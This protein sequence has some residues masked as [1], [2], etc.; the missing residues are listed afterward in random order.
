MQRSHQRPASSSQPPVAG[1]PAGRC[2]LTRRPLSAEAQPGRMPA[3]AHTSHPNHVSSH[4]L[5]D[6]SCASSSLQAASITACSIFKHAPSSTACRPLGSPPLGRSAPPHA[7]R[8]AAACFYLTPIVLL[9]PSTSA[10]L[11]P[12]TI[13]PPRRLKDCNCLLLFRACQ[14]LLSTAC[15]VFST[16][17][18]K[19]RRSASSL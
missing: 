11:P 5:P 3:Q 14:C 2:V 7:S 8:S 9:P 4:S 12:D 16:L 6:W 1:S 13:D 18:F 15:Q 19:K 17:T 10:G